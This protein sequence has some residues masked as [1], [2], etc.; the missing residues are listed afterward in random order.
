MSVVVIVASDIVWSPVL[1]QLVFPI[2]VASASVTKFLSVP[3]VMLV[4]ARTGEAPLTTLWS[5]AFTSAI[6]VSSLS[7][8]A[9]AAVTL[10]VSVTSAAASIP[11]SFVSSAVVKL[12][13]VP[14][15]TASCACTSTPI[16]T[17]RD[18]L[19]SDA[20]LAPVPHCPILS[21]LKSAIVLC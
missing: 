4:V 18:V 12:A 14:S 9:H 17:H 2:T 11:E 8:K 13:V 3:S 7:I 10:V 16:S 6:E 1:V 19:A 20:V 15:N 5:N 21:A